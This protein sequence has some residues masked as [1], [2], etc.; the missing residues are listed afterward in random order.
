M[1]SI[2]MMGKIRNGYFLVIF[3]FLQILPL[4]KFLLAESRPLKEAK[5]FYF[6]Q[7]GEYYSLYKQLK[8]F[9]LTRV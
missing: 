9:K 7:S 1:L 6:I 5:Y 2:L 8:S 4:I 3:F